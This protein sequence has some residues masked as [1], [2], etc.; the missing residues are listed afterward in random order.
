MHLTGLPYFK[1]TQNFAYRTTDSIIYI[2]KDR[3]G[4][5]HSR[6]SEGE[7]IKVFYIKTVC[8]CCYVT[9]ENTQVNLHP[10]LNSGAPIQR[11]N[12]SKYVR[13]VSNGFL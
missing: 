11:R 9:D 10:C 3:N 13:S 8:G 6:F 5:G 2:A 7:V 1:W 4:T 12:V